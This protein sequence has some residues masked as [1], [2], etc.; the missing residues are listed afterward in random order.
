MLY[1]SDGLA[2]EFAA[3]AAAHNYRAAIVREFHDALRG[4]VLEVGAG[5]G[6][7]TESLLNAPSVDEI[8]ALEPD[9][10]FEAAFRKHLPNTRLL[11][12]SLEDLQENETFDTGVMVNVLEHI[13]DDVG[14][15]RCLRKHLAGPQSSVCLLVPARP[16][17]FAKIDSQFGHFRRYTSESLRGCLQQAGFHVGRLH[18]FN[19][20]GYFLWYLN[21]TLRGA[22][23][24]NPSLVGFFDRYVFR[25]GN[26]V[27]TTVCRPCIGQ[28][29]IAIATPM[30]TE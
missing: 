8:V 19:V 22:T 27:E 23:S 4:K 18:Y 10:T 14:A 15:L 24:F 11:Q 3:L 2:F 20:I 17:L 13:E 26:L 5:I 30:A 21:F 9:R 25:L 28:S 7:M 16:E 12:G 1:E 29:L 6:Q